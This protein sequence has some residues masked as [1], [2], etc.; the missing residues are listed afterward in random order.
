MSTNELNLVAN[1]KIKLPADKIL[2]L[3]G[4]VGAPMLLLQFL[5]GGIAQNTIVQNNNPIVSALGILY[6]GGWMCGAIGMFRQKVYGEALAAKIVFALQMIFLTLAF[7]FSVQETYGITYENGGVFFGVCDAGY[8][9]SHLFMFVIGIFILRAKKWKGLT[10]FAPFFVG[11]ALPL[12]MA[13]AGFVGFTA[14]M[15]LFS[16]LT[17]IGLGMIGYLVYSDRN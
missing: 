4:I 7:L 2:G 6:I 17:T 11:A 15:L 3:L 16:G 5:T 1:Q 12:T 9:L 10:R 14:G 13:V 8:P